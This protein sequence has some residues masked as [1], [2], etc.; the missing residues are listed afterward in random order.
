MGKIKSEERRNKI[1]QLIESSDEPLSGSM[2]A[3]RFGVSRQVIVTD[4]AILK[5][6]EPELVSTPKGYI[7]MRSEAC[8]CVFK[9]MHTEDQT[10]D[11]L[12]SI[13]ELGG[14]IIDVYVNHRV[15]GTIRRPLDINSKRDVDNFIKDIKGGVST[16]L[17]NIT[18]GYHFHTI[19]AKSQSA[20]TEIEKT[21][22]EK[23]YLI[24][25][26]PSPVIYGPKDYGKS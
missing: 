23:G 5:N 18:Q 15:Y 22:K 11:E 6:K 19:A 13:V 1:L 26:L 2:I 4:M 25:V 14:R 16:H 24:E 21:L 3:E 9:V 20:L 7:M 8:R 17:M 10:E 12:T